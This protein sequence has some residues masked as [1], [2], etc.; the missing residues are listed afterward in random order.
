MSQ[1]LFPVLVSVCEVLDFVSFLASVVSVVS[2]SLDPDS[3]KILSPY[4]DHCG[5]FVL[6]ANKTTN[7]PFNTCFVLNRFTPFMILG[8]L[9]VN[10]NIFIQKQTVYPI[11]IEQDYFLNLRNKAEWILVYPFCFSLNNENSLLLQKCQK[12]FIPNLFV[13]SDCFL[14]FHKRMIVSR[15]CSSAHHKLVS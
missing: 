4:T 9:Y 3:E 6:T 14:C 2:T 1:P 13:K 11:K 7:A 10:A 12:S 5:T 8:E 15:R